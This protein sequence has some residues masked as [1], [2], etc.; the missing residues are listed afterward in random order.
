M[1][2]HQK[3]EDIIKAI[4]YKKTSDNIVINFTSCYLDYGFPPTY[5]G[6]SANKINPW[7]YDYIN[8]SNMKLGIVVMD[9]MTIDLAKA[10]Y[11]R[12]YL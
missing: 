9:F 3:K 7:F 4:E 8:E 5:A 11:M 1:K 12:N 6:S 2:E 10:I